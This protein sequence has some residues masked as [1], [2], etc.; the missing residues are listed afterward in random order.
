MTINKLQLDDV[1]IIFDDQVVLSGVDLKVNDGEIIS[2]MG[3]S[4]S[5]RRLLFDQ[6]QDLIE[7]L[8]V[9]LKLMA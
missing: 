2:L 3:S 4:A 8:Q 6:L 9:Q 1:K 5:G 7:F